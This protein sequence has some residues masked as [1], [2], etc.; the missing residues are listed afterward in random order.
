M[1]LGDP[2]AKYWHPIK[3]APVNQYIVTRRPMR[4]PTIA[5]LCNGYWISSNGNRIMTPTEW[6][7]LVEE[8]DA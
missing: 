3:N 7:Y 2:L 4:C 6:R 5:Y 8:L 1:K